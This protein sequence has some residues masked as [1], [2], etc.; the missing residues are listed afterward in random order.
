MLIYNWECKKKSLFFQARFNN[1]VGY[2]KTDYIG[3][4]HSTAKKY[5]MRP[6][7]Y[8]ALAQALANQ[9]RKEVRGV[10]SLM[11]CLSE[12]LAEK[13]IQ[14]HTDIRIITLDSNVCCNKKV[15]CNGLTNMVEG[16]VVLP[17]E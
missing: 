5:L 10:T 6:L 15:E 14:T 16:T 12:G 8:K 4:N 9:A 7:T 3:Q 1:Y 17:L 11:E 2:M 13:K